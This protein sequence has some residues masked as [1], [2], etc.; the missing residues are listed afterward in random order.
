MEMEVNGK[1][2]AVEDQGEGDA[3]VMVHGLGGTGNTWHPQAGP[4][5]RFFRVIRLD[6]EGSGRSPAAGDLSIASFAADAIAVMDALD[7]STAHLCGH[8]MGTIVCQHLAAQHAERV[9]SL[10]LLGPLAEPPEP[11]R[12]AIRDRAAV[13][14]KSGMVPIADT[15][16][17]VA[18]S[19]ETRSHQPATAAFVREILMRQDAEG[20]ARTCEALADA[21]SAELAAIRCPTLLITGDEDGV[22]PPP[23]VRALGGR[24]AGSRVAVLPGCGHWTPVEKPAQVNGLLLNFYFSF[25]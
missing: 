3:V 14:R 18:I 16:V 1:Q 19:A 2:I 17:E 4:L 12:Q 23:A 10:A 7:I 8:S 11:A 9:K 6:L 15:L 25:N 21:R 22:A 5:A 24:I 20:Y 13:A